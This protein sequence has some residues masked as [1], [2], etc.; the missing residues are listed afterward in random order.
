MI[1]GNRAMLIL[2]AAVI[3]HLPSLHRVAVPTRRVSQT[4]VL[5]VPIVLPFCRI[6]KLRRL[7]KPAGFE[8]NPFGK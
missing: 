7:N 1:T 4:D 2:P 8:P 3:L 5:A 6:N